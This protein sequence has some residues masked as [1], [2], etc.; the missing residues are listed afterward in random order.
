MIKTAFSIVVI[1]H[2]LIHLLGFVKAFKLAPVTQL[3]QPISKVNGAIWGGG[4]LLFVATA[5]LYYLNR[6]GWWMPGIAAVLGSQYLIITSW[7]DAKFGTIANV[8]IVLAIAI[9][10][11]AWH[12]KDQYVQLATAN[13]HQTASAPETTLT[14]ADL[15]GLPAPV[16]KY[17]HYTQVVN[18]PKVRNFKVRF[19]GQIRKSEQSAWMPFSADQ[20]SFMDASTRLFFMNATMRSFPISAFHC[21]QNGDAFMDIRLFSLFKIQYQTGAEMGIAETVTFFN[22]ICCMA[23]AALIDKRIQWLETKGNEVKAS[24]T[25]NNITISAWLFFDDQGALVNFTSEDRYAAS[26]HGIFRKVPWSTPIKSYRDYNGYHLPDFA[27]TVYT[28]PDGD[29]RYG[30][31]KI[32]SIEYNRTEFK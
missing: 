5:V 28:Y 23:P 2:G 25:N 29:L 14:E 1:L 18:K 6:D 3:T 17:L 32:E 19:T 24:F 27:I 16:Q 13:L 31:F 7:Q 15:Q 8:L 11:S 22:D 12:F 30:E 21:F 4:A 20:Y 26:D 10:Y 9:G